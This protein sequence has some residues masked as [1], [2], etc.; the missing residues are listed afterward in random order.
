MLVKLV[1]AQ[2]LG[3]TFGLSYWVGVSV[4]ELLN[5]VCL[6]NCVRKIK[7][8]ANTC[9]VCHVHSPCWGLYSLCCQEGHLWLVSWT[10]W[11]S[12]GLVAWESQDH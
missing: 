6:M 1:M 7:S 11:L 2:G 3:G 5:A 9:V 8:V 4:T 12:V 10:G